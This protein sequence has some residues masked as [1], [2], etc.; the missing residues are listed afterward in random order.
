VGGC[1]GQICSDQPD[2]AS[3]C[4]WRE[5]YACYKTARCEKQASG[6]CGWT[7]TAELNMCLNKTRQNAT[8][9]Y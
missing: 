2:M 3:T 6:Q 5:E 9:V 4:E 1:S 7:A 8:D